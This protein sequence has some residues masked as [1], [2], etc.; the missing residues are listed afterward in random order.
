MA[1]LLDFQCR[2]PFFLLKVSYALARTSTTVL[3]SPDG[4]VHRCH[5]PSL[6]GIQPFTVTYDVI[7]VGFLVQ[8]I[9]W[10]IFSSVASIVYIAGFDLLIFC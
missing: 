1:L 7:C 10:R 8:F 5:V 2:S 9:K 3:D 4:S 6:R